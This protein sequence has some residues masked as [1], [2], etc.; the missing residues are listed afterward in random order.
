MNNHKEIED[1]KLLIAHYD[2]IAELESKLKASLLREQKLKQ[3]LV[4]MCDLTS[5]A[6]YDFVVYPIGA[7]RQ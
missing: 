4:A 5:R 3:A 7:G 2:H 6:E 1:G